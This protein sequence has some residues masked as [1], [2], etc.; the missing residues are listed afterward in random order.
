P[1]AFGVLGTFNAMIS[2]IMPIAALAYPIAIV[3]PKNDQ[4]A[5]GIIRLS[6]VI[7]VFITLLSFI[8]IL[9]FNQQ[10]VGIFNLHE[11]LN[12]LYFIPFVIIFAGFVQV[13]EQWLIRTKQFSITAQT[14]FLHSII[15][16]GSKVAIG[17][18][19]PVATVLVS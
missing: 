7:T 14:T 2:I 15:M 18:F 11:F 8:I 6:L 17:F 10:I 3:L 16:N 13:I 19:Q 4:D 9:L 12:Y 5:K 1:E